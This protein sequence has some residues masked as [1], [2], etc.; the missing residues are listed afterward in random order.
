MAEWELETSELLPLKNEIS[1]KRDLESAMEVH[2]DIIKNRI[3]MNFNHNY[4]INR[5]MDSL[6]AM[7]DSGQNGTDLI[8]IDGYDFNR[9]AIKDIE[10]IKAFA[11]EKE[12]EVWFSDTL[13]PN[14][15]DEDGVPT[16]EAI[17][18]K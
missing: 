8:I 2:D 1:K 14:S 15:E 4:P 18:F 3:I 16:I 6:T 10:I 7:I 11:E 17:I 13:Y 12:V 9:G 5:I